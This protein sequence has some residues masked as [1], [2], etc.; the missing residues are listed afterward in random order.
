MS[1]NTVT[2]SLDRF[3]EME[4]AV[5]NQNAGTIT[6]IRVFQKRV[7]CAEFIVTKTKDE[8]MLEMAEFY[9]SSL[10]EMKITAD[11]AVDASEEAMKMAE[12]LKNR[13]LFQRI[14]NIIPK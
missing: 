2:I 11:K 3:K 12:K 13:N 5:A 8:V 1:V 10:R 4:A 6:L 7:G 9:N 14:F